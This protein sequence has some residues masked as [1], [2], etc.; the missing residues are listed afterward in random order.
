MNFH[1]FKKTEMGGG[2]SEVGV[3][4]LLAVYLS[5]LCSENT[6]YEV[7]CKDCEECILCQWKK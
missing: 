1:A 5:A 6:K 4:L 7:T 3:P 2:K